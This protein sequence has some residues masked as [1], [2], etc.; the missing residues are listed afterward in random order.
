MFKTKPVASMSRRGLFTAVFYVYVPM[1]P[2]LR[3]GGTPSQGTDARLREGTFASGW[4]K[5]QST[6]TLSR[7]IQQRPFSPHFSTRRNYGGGVY[8]LSSTGVHKQGI[9]TYLQQQ[10][11]APVHSQH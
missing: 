5:R 11:T 2:R 6:Y 8:I 10:R 4:P 9:S 3:R 7:L 1:L